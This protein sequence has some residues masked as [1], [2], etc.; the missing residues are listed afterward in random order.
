MGDEV[1]TDDFSNL[2]ENVDGLTTQVISLT[3]DLKAA[4]DTI[5]ELLATVK[6]LQTTVADLQT[7]ATKVNADLYETVKF[8]RTD[9][10]LDVDTATATGILTK[11]TLPTC[12][13]LQTAV[14]MFAAPKS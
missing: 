1:S 14:M 4:N 13:T 6:E 9:I 2:K 11:D 5:T 7:T 3:D 12:P 8:L 10:T